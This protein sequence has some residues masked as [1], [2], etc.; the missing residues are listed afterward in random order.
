MNILQDIKKA[1]AV[2]KRLACLHAHYSNVE[3]IEQA[4][5]PYGLELVHYTDPGLI[6]RMSSDPRFSQA[7]ALEHATN[8][9]EWMMDCGADAV[10][11]TCTQYAALL[12]ESRQEW[13]VPVITINEPFFDVLCSNEQP[14]I[15]LFTNPGTVEGTMRRL[16]AF[17]DEVGKVPQVEAQL[18]EGSFGLIMEGKK[19]EYLERVSGYMKE[20]IQTGE[21]RMIFAAQLSMT[22]AAEAVERQCRCEIGNPLKA[23]VPSLTVTL[24]LERR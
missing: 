9:L 12:E 13:Q 1:G 14:Q 10:L 16:H 2:M 8:Q 19:E 6:R 22:E 17:A 11:V 5:A 15:V 4:L 24:G 18:I 20:L 7:E 21:Q 3:Y 23:L